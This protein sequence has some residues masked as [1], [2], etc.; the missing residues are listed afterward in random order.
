[1]KLLLPILLFLTACGPAHYVQVE[2]VSVDRASL[3][4]TF[5]RSPDPNQIKPPTGEKLYINWYLPFSIK[6]EEY[7]LVLSVIYKNLTQEQKIYDIPTR[8]GFSSFSLID[9]KY[10]ETKGFYSYKVELVNKNDGSIKDTWEHQMW[11][12]LL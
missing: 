12:T 2:K 1:M 11:V 7:Q 4:S 3:A 6:P 8:I 5:A 9:K 10:Q